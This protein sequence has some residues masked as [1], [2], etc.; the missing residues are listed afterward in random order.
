M[1]TYEVKTCKD[2]QQDIFKIRGDYLAYDKDQISVYKKNGND[3]TLMA[4]FQFWIY[5][6][7]LPLAEEKP[8]E[9]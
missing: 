5:G 2:G 3:N 4:S 1:K 6:I 8:P 7:E 9:I